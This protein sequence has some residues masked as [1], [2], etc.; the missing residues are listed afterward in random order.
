VTQGDTAF[1]D[2][3]LS[4]GFNVGDTNQDNV[5]QTGE[6]WQF[7]GSYTVTQADIDNRDA[8]GIPTV[9]PTLSHDNTA[10]YFT[11]QTDSQSVSA[12]VPIAQNPHVML[13]KAASVADGTADHAGDVINYT[14]ALANN[15]NMSLTSPAVSDPFVSNLAPVLAGGF[16]TGDANSDGELS[17]GETWQYTASHTL[18]QAEIDN[19]GVVDPGLAVSNTASATTQQGASATA[20]AS[21]P[22]AQHPHVTLAKT[23]AVADGTADAAGDVINY[24]IALTND[25]NMT[26]TTPAVS[27]PFVSNLAPVL[28]G[29]FNAGDTNHDGKLG[30]TESWQYTANHTVTQAEI[31]NGGVVD[32]ALAISNTASASTAQGASGTA[33]ASVAVVQ[34]PDLTVAKTADVASVNAAGQII[35][36]TVTVGNAGNMTLTGIV[37]SD[38]FVAD[39]AY[40]SGDTN[41]NS[42]LDLTETWTYAGSHTVTQGDIDGGT[43]NNTATADSAQTSPETASA[44]VAVAQH[45][46]MTLTKVGTVVDS[47]GDGITN[48]GDTIHY[49]F[50]ETNTGN[51][52]QHDIGVTD[53]A[54]TVTGSPIASLAPGASDSITWSASYTILQFDI[55]QGHFDNEAVANSTTNNATATERVNL[56]PHMTLTGTATDANPTPTAGD[57]LVYDFSLTNDGN[58]TL[59]APTVSDTATTGVTVAQSGPNIVGDANN[60]LLFDVGETWMFTGTRT[61]SAGDI[62]NGVPDTAI[63]TATGLQN[64]HA[65]ATASLVFPT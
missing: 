10:F 47:N 35:H 48:A 14:I 56:R 23:A 21:V 6:A 62:T 65:S 22:I 24:A 44:S 46:A 49:T 15:G 31:D 2:P 16:N 38:P 39:L 33:T 57:S 59:H 58:V 41:S 18:T 43:I 45:P 12:S 26:L 42:K 5:M 60:N 17:V 27:D 9:D 52:T 25:G 29:G 11:D 4:G 20:T 32:P 3:V 36:Y 55:N 7:A 8:G 30:L 40:V 54:V 50:T 37:V 51:V 1:V 19:G 53:E 63:A 34:N 13:A 61:L 28:S 64:Q